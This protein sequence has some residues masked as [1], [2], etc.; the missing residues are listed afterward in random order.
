MMFDPIFNFFL[1]KIYSIAGN[2]CQKYE[3]VDTYIFFSCAYNTT[4]S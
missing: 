3:Q 4:N 2:Y 1:I